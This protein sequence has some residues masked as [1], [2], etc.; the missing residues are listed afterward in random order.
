MGTQTRALLCGRRNTNVLCP[1]QGKPNPRRNNRATEVCVVT[2]LFDKLKSRLERDFIKCEDLA[3]VLALAI[4]SGKNVLLW[5]PGGHG[6]SEM[7]ETALAEIVTDL[8]NEVHVQ[9]FGEGMDEA[10]LW[11]G[12]DFRALETEKVLRYFPELSFLARPYAVFEELFDAPASVLLALKDTLTARKLRKGSQVFAMKTKVIIA[13]TNKDPAEIS[14]LGPAA[15]ALIERFPIQL[16]V[17]WPSYKAADYSELFVKVAPRLPGA[18][19]NG[20]SSV[21]AEMLGKL[22]EQGRPI[23][24]RSAVHALGVVKTSAALRGSAKVEKVDLLDLKFVDGFEAL[25]ENLKTELD[26]ASERA[27]AEVLLVEAEGELNSLLSDLEAADRTQSPV[28]CNQAALRLLSFQDKV[29]NLKV[30][31]GLTE[32]RKQLREAASQKS[33]EAQKLSLKHT[34]L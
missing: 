34:R 14:E 21:L 18:D 17:K 4:T 7:I 23:S 12:L 13:L 8:D 33:A 32:K 2:N 28:K 1:P 29:A 30:T 6:K 15:H 5:G 19:L 31:D 27:T 16:N 3:R 20:M 10:T 22:A 25:A 26:K 9:S 11:G 24:P